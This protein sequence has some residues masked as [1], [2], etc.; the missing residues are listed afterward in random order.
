MTIANSARTSL[1]ICRA[2]A[3]VPLEAR[4]GET[5]R[6]DSVPVGKRVDDLPGHLPSSSPRVFRHCWLAPRV[7]INGV[8]SGDRFADRRSSG[9]SGDN[10]LP[11]VREV[12]GISRRPDA[13]TA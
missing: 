13:V 7:G 12:C 6:R 3:A 10:D 8:S 9:G 11:T 5:M 2:H 1:L 4:V